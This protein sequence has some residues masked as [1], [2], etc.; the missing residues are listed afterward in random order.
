MNELIIV[1][2][3]LVIIYL[4]IILAWKKWYKVRWSNANLQLF[5]KNWQRIQQE[6][7]L[8]MRVIE[9]DKLLDIMLRK[10][11]VEGSLGEKL[12]KY[13]SNFSDLDG[14]WRAHKL[15]NKLAHEM[16]LKIASAEV[17]VAIK[18]FGRAFKD[19]GL[20]E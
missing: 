17:D 15:R 18:T 5:N 16:G 6:G 9:A 13:G 4:I 20:I 19:L 7:D 3:V 14:L 12:K 2:I 8:R 10:R 11:N 1:L